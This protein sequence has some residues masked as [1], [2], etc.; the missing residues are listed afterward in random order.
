MRAVRFIALVSAAGL[1]AAVL[2]AQPAV[3]DRYTEGDPAR[4]MV[5]APRAAYPHAVVPAPGHQRLDIRRVF[6]RHTARVLIIRVVVRALTRPEGEDYFLGGFV[7]VNRQA[8]PS[9]Y[10][11]N[12][13]Q[14]AVI[15]NE[16]H[17]RHASSLGVHD[18]DEDDLPACQRGDGHIDAVA[19]YNGNWITVTI[20][21]GCLASGT[22][23]A[24]LEWVRAAVH[25]SHSP[26]RVSYR[27][28][29]WS[30]SPDPWL[31]AL[32]D[33]GTAHFTPRLYAG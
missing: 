24:V 4:D 3:A 28:R 6:V 19:H 30:R 23:P 21:R 29:L 16:K 1:V 14:W 8:R 5:A 13:W 33:R 15:F 32:A 9:P 20:P 12:P 26:G 17:V 18:A 25:C 2:A 22:S 7:Q 27:D 10:D 11:D 31:P